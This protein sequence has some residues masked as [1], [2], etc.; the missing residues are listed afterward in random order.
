[1]RLKIDDVMTD[2]VIIGISLIFV[3]SSIFSNLFAYFSIQSDP[4]GFIYNKM[5]LTYN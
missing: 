4:S 1:M 5:V 3:F 2:D